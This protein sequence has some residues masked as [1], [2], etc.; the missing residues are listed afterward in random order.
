MLGSYSL[1]GSGG[2]TTIPDGRFSFQDVFCPAQDRLDDEDWIDW[3]IT[4]SAK[5]E[6]GTHVTVQPHRYRNPCTASLFF[7][8][9]AVDTDRSR[10]DTVHVLLLA[11]VCDI[12]QPLSRR[13]SEQLSV[14]TLR[15]SGQVVQPLSADDAYSMLNHVNRAVHG[16][17]GDNW[18]PSDHQL[19]ALLQNLPE[20]AFI[21]SADGEVLWFSD[22]WC[23]Y[24]SC[25]LSFLFILWPHSVTSLCE[26]ASRML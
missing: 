20:I 23:E 9:A 17:G 24:V 3:L 14:A 2:T 19:Q 16:A 7:A 6:F 21:G 1:G 22:Q 25:A 10:I 12:E 5:A 15:L 26:V 13:L 8:S 11:P 4:E 18:C